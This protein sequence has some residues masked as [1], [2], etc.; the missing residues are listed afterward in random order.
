MGNVCALYKISSP[1]EDVCK[2]CEVC[3][4]D[5]KLAQGENDKIE[6]TLKYHQHVLQVR[7]ERDL[8]MELVEKSKSMFVNREQHNQAADDNFSTNDVH[9]TFDVS[10]YVKLPHHAQEKGPIFFIQSR[11]VQIFGFR[12]DGYK[13]YNY[14]IDT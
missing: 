8:Y 1:K 9:Y 11:K 13:Q 5:I 4:Q 3:K 7:K 14:L 12:A 6:A 2:A 10:Q